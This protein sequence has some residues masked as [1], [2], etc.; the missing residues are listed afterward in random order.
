MSNEKHGDVIEPVHSSTDSVNIGKVDPE[1]GEV[2]KTGEGLV[3]FR[4]VSWIH[5]SVI[6]LKRALSPRPLPLPH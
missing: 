3:N 1:D 5:T 2:F 4:T 6:F